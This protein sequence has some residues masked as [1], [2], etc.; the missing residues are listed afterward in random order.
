MLGDSF[1]SSSSASCRLSILPERAQKPISR[2]PIGVNISREVACFDFPLSLGSCLS[3]VQ[4]LEAW[5]RTVRDLAL[6]TLSL[7][8]DCKLETVNRF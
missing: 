6:N 8:P 3:N 5:I 4:Q 7:G 2:A 1:L